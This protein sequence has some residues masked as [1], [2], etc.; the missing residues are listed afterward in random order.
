VIAAAD[1]LG[2]IIATLVTAGMGGNVSVLTLVL[3]AVTALILTVDFFRISAIIEFYDRM[4][5]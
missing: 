2:G 4:K 5:E 1:I 3:W